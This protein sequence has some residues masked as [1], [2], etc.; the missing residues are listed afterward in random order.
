MQTK[1][2]TE[3]C[4]EWSHGSA[5]AASSPDRTMQPRGSIG[6]VDPRSPRSLGNYR[7]NWIN[8]QNNEIQV[9]YTHSSSLDLV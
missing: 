6:Q 3:I 5:Y 1:A 9:Q 7:F 8:L 2:E 4:E